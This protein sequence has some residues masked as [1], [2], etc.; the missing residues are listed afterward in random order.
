[1]SLKKFETFAVFDLETSCLPGPGRRA[2]ITEITIYAVSKNDFIKNKSSYKRIP[3]IVNKITLLVQPLDKIDDIA[4]EISGLSNLS[5]QNESTWDASTSEMVTMFLERLQQPVCLIAHNGDR[6][7]FPILKD[8]FTFTKSDFL[9]GA[10]AVDSLKA[11]KYIDKQ[12]DERNS[13]YKLV[14]VFKRT[15]GLEPKNAH[16]A[17]GDVQ[18]L[19]K[20]MLFYGTDFLEYCE[21]KA[22]K[23]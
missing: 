17:E 9:E 11:F 1:M 16:E 3:R 19:L 8:H 14:D 12:R 15:T 10:L 20:T 21:K 22:I 23:F 18:M 7:D 5:L 13:S 4:A 6:F 2:N